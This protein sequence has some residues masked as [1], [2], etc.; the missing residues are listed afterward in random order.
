MTHKTF[1]FDPRNEDQRF[2]ERVRL[3]DWI[4]KVVEC[5]SRY[6]SGVI[7]LSAVVQETR[8]Y[9]TVIPSTP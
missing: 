5:R 1:L 2:D 6:A 3:M 7:R 8:G 4:K 9:R